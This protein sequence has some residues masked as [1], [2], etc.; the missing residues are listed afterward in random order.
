MHLSRDNPNSSWQGPAS[1]AVLKALVA[2]LNSTAEAVLK[3]GVCSWQ[4][5]A[6]LAEEVVLVEKK[7]GRKLQFKEG[8]S[9]HVWWF[10]P[11]PAA[12]TSGHGV[13]S[14]RIWTEM[15]NEVRLLEARI[16]GVIIQVNLFKPG[17]YHH[18]NRHLAETFR[19]LADQVE[20]APVE[21]A[22]NT[23]RFENGAWR[24]S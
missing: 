21:L 5:P 14:D 15:P 8:H 17:K 23:V 13:A 20:Q 18:S 7:A 11:P 19:R 24:Q 12:S 2:G 9:D 4:L 10:F 1:E 22:D 3:V 16:N 6:V